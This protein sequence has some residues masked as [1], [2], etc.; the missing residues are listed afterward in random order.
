MD[1]PIHI[2]TI[3]SRDKLFFSEIRS[4]V[5]KFHFSSVP[6]DN[7]K[8]AFINPHVFSHSIHFCNYSVIRYNWVI[9]FPLTVFN[10]AER[11][12]ICQHNLSRLFLHMMFIL[13]IYFYIQNNKSEGFNFDKPC[14]V[15]VQGYMS[16]I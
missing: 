13:C 15:A 7:V 8:T 11:E 12:A 9:I 10:C 3:Q 1:F 16:L 4:R 6:A 5:H 2:D 14:S